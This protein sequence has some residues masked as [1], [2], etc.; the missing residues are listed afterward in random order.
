MWTTIISN[1]RSRLIESDGDSTVHISLKE[2]CGDVLLDAATRAFFCERQLEIQPDLFQRFFEFDDDSWMLLYRYPRFLS[3][4]M[5]RA[6]DVAIDAMTKSF[7]LTLDRRQDAAWFV[8]TLEKEQKQLGID[9]RD[10]ATL[11]L[12]VYW[13]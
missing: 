10:I 13:V 11:Q 8:Q 3:R 6:K 4:R 5:H 9:E 1:T 12:M 2:W 7:E